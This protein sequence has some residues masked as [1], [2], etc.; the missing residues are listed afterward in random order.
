MAYG[1]PAFPLAFVALPLYVVLPHHYAQAFGVPLTILGALLMVARL[2]DA[3]IDP[4]IGRAVDRLWR[5]GARL[6]LWICTICAGA[7]AAAF[8]G[9]FFPR[10]SE[11]PALIAWA[12][13]ML[14]IAYASYSTISVVHQSWGAMLADVDSQR[15]RVVAWREG[16]A[17]AGVIA[18]SALS[19]ATGPVGMCLALAISLALALP[20]WSRAPRPAPVARANLPASVSHPLRQ[21]GFRALLGVYLLNGIASAIPATL[22][23]FYVQ[24]RLQAGPAAA[25]WLLSIYFVTAALALPAWSRLVDRMGLARTWL[26][27][28]LLAVCAFASAALLGPGDVTAFAL[29]CAAS[30]IALGADLTVPAAMLAGLI[31]RD[32]HGNQS[33]GTYFGWWNLATKLNLALAA[34]LALPLL[35]LAGYSPGARDSQGLHA[36]ALAYCALPCSL[37]LLA[38]LFLRRHFIPRSS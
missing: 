35:A 14:A 15:A 21:P 30:G 36:L 2:F 25:P 18:A 12:A 37:K 11:E 13:A 24:D 8:A 16:F 26:A 20:A 3:L 4:W 22:V 34:G 33:E 28:M 31:A 5:H 6:L 17:L 19:T 38:A 27:G 9:L 10:F 29:V 32:G 1:L 7:L 23:L